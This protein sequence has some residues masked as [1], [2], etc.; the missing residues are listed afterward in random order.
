MATSAASGGGAPAAAAAAAPKDASPSSS[1]RPKVLILTGPTAVG[2]TKASLALAEALGGE[3]I[4]ADSVQ[5]YRRLD[6]GSDKI[7]PEE[8]RGIPHHLIDVLDP[9][10]EFSAG[11]FFTLARSAAE[12]ILRRGRTPIVVGGTG[13]YL[14]WFI[15]GKPA[16]PGATPASEA[17]AH[18]RLEQAYAEAA[19]AAGKA[20]ADLAPEERWA[21]GCALIDALGDA[22]SA[23]RLRGERNN[24][25]RLLRVVDILLQTGGRTLAELDLDAQRPTDYD[26]RCFF[27]HRPRAELYRRIDG[28]VEEM[29]AGGLLTECQEVLLDAGIAP[30]S[31]CA[32]RAIGYRQAGEAL[33]RWHADP[34][35]LTEQSVIQAVQAVQAASRQLCHKQMTW[36]RDEELFRWIDA[37]QGEEA[38]LAE[39]LQRWAAPQHEG[40]CGD[41][42]RLTK[43]Q[44]RE[45]RRYVTKLRLYYKGSPEMQKTLEEARQLV[46]ARAGQAAPA[47]QPARPPPRTAAATAAAVQGANL[48]SE[49][50]PAAPAAAP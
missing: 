49:G 45:M 35:S 21:A 47:R 50:A 10:A 30:N 28:R 32:S 41:S 44:E 2:K 18:E 4:S 23:E 36:F 24:Q 43:E 7:R 40:G 46:A 20:A 38:V 33:Q 22:A 5:V 17:A 48:D 31:N 8:Q 12:D 3:I 13:F 19:A 9:E 16:T 29:M 11:D 39:M 6:I 37:T 42:G 26:C 34:E 25:Y 27:L 15:H 1:A 14:R